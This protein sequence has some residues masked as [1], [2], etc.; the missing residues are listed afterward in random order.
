MGTETARRAAEPRVRQRPR[1]IAVEDQPV[2]EGSCTVV[3]T[4]YGVETEERETIRVP[5]FHTE[6]ARVGLTAGLTR[7]LGGYEFARFDVTVSL[8]CY[9]EESEVHRAYAIVER[10]VEEKVQAQNEAINTAMSGNAQQQD[11]G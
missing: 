4:M 8:P 9:P 7:S 6:P 2:H 1:A 3:R 11:V 5:L 10:I